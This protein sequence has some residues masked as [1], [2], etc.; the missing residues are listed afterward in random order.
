MKIDGALNCDNEPIRFPGAIQP[1]GA[2]LVLQASSGI[3]EAASESCAVLLG[4]SAE[5]L[6]GQSIGSFLGATSEALILDAVLKHHDSLIALL[7]KGKNLLARPQL[8]AAGQ[9]LLDIETGD[10]NLT[11]AGEMHYRFRREISELRNLTDVVKIT[12]RAAHFI[13]ELTHFDRVMIYRFDS[14]WNGAVIAEASVEGLE[15][16]LGLNFPASDIPSQARELYKSGKVRQITDALYQPSPLIALKGVP[17]V[18]LSVSSL[19]SISPYHIEYMCN[20]QVRA[21]LACP[22]IIEG[23]LWGLLSCQQK[24]EPKYFGFVERDTLGWF[25]EDMAAHIETTLFREKRDRERQLSQLRRNLLETVRCADIRIQMHQGMN[26]GLLKVLDADGFAFL[27]GDE[28]QATGITPDNQRIKELLGR[29]RKLGG[30]PLVYASNSLGRDLGPADGNDK[31]AG[32][33]FVSLQHISDV[34]MIWFRQERQRTLRWGGDP[35]H[36]HLIDNQGRISPRKSFAQFIKSIQGSSLEWSAEELDSAQELGSIIEIEQQRKDQQLAQ[37]IFDSSPECMAVLDTQGRIQLVNSSWKNFVQEIDLPQWAENWYGMNYQKIL[38]KAVSTNAEAPSAWQGVIA[39][40][41]RKL[42]SFTLEYQYDSPYQ[43]MFYCMKVYPVLG[44]V[45]EVVVA[46]ANITERK[47][48]EA[49]LYASEQ[50]CKLALEGAGEG[51]WEHHLQTDTIKLSK[52]FEE[53]LGFAEGQL[54]DACHLWNN[55]IYAEDQA[56]ALNNLKVYLEGNAGVYYNEFRMR[57]KDGTYKWVLARGMVTERDASGKPSRLI[58]TLA[59]ISERKQAE[60]RL[61]EAQQAADAANFAKSRFLATMSHELRT[62]LNGILGMAQVMAQPQLLEADRLSYAQTILRSGNNLLILLNDILDLSKVEAGKIDLECIAFCPA[63]LIDEVN[64]CYAEAAINK[65][66]KLKIS[67][68]FLLEQHYLG[69]PHRLRQI[70]NNLVSNALKFTREG[71]V[72]IEG[73]EISRDKDSAVLEFAV[74]DTGIGIAKDKL[75]ALFKPFSQIDSSITRQYG[76]TGLGL[77][78]VQKLAQQMGGDTGISS[79]PGQ[80]S[81]FWFTIK[82]TVVERVTEL[83]SRV[84]SVESLQLTG[85]VPLVDDSETNRNVIT[86]MLRQSD[87]M[88]HLAENGLEAVDWITQQPVDLVLMDV[89]MPVMD[90]YETTRNI[91]LWEANQN[92][93]P[94]PIIALTAAAYAEDRQ[95]C[96]AAGMDDFIAKP[97]YFEKLMETLARWLPVVYS[98]S[99]RVA[100]TEP[101]LSDENSGRSERST[102]LTIARQGDA[103]IKLNTEAQPVTIYRELEEMLLENRFGAIRQFRKLQEANISAEVAAQLS[104]IAPLLNELHFAAVLEQ[105]M[106]IALALGWKENNA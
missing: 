100:P 10:F 105:L 47:N 39:V 27:V 99:N 15:P 62:P 92:K 71:M 3:V 74:I 26:Y 88:L 49:A 68:N 73:R 48:A 55:C 70:L 89:Q 94:L 104:V 17:P 29:R 75:A 64:K 93:Q 28:V 20:M 63:L 23:R 72:L 106:P 97:I 35:G 90:G 67:V 13:Q 102:D 56:H 69:D 40:L 43:S 31:I 11:L 36:A 19:R 18:D 16:Y 58:G 5:S 59:D 103:L 6:L 86:A 85:R 54:G 78:I 12:H 57:C 76:G 65:D 82:A 2:L 30:N 81:R 61:L 91:R 34:T 22:L 24:N 7:L 66:L 33:L 87:I 52:R 42:D 80:G 51:V 1:H 41:G 101:P 96:L 8:N 98:E 45:Q 37:T 21:T 32:A 60:T 95:R 83:R 9:I 14:D 53:I 77:S 50:L 46:H 84:N 44:S 25:C 38:D 4:L 79:E